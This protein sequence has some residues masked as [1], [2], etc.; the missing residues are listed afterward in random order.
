[1]KTTSLFTKKKGSSSSKPPLTTSSRRHSVS[2]SH[3]SMEEYMAPPGRNDTL[4]LGGFCTQR[5][6]QQEEHTA[7]RTELLRERRL[8]HHG[9]ELRQQ[10]EHTATR[11][12]IPT[13]RCVINFPSC[14]R[15]MRGLA[16]CLIT[17]M[18]CLE[19]PRK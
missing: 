2:E 14:A 15:R 13:T 19:R 7:T 10:E 18:T 9:A 11:T 5:L 4:L 12:P 1:M 3:R 16:L 8:L 6:G 17:V